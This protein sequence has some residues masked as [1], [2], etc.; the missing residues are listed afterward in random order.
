MIIEILSLGSRVLDTKFKDYERYGIREYWIM[1]PNHVI[2][3]Q[4]YTLEDGKY[5][6]FFPENHI[7]HSKIVTG[8][9]V[10]LKALEQKLK[11]Y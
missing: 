1:E 4:F 11:G 9:T 5:H 7:I 6:E 2:S 8:F 3:S 10:N